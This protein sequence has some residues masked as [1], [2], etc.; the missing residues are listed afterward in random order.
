MNSKQA[1]LYKSTSFQL[2]RLIHRSIDHNIP[3][4]VG[5]N[6]LKN[7]I[8]QKWR[9]HRN[10]SDPKKIEQLFLRAHATLLASVNP[11]DMKAS[12]LF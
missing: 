5:K 12:H 6:F 7:R 2:Y 8:R 3:T 10:E 9:E 11:E 4:V 1:K